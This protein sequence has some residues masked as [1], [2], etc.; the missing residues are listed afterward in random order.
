MVLP[1][2]LNTNRND[3]VPAAPVGALV[4]AR[5]EIL[6]TKK[7]QKQEQYANSTITSQI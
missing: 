3:S 4:A 7:Q 6:S 2:S 1:P 5:A